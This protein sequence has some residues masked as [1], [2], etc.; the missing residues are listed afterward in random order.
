LFGQAPLLA[1]TYLPT[2]DYISP[3]RP[4]LIIIT[5]RLLVGAEYFDEN[6][7]WPS[8]EYHLA[9]AKPSPAIFRAFCAKTVAF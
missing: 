8:E 1:L 4:P 6:Y 9:P 2:G 3:A 5:F 7:T